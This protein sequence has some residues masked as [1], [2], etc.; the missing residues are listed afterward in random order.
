MNGNRLAT[1]YILCAFWFLGL[2][3]LHRLYNGKIGTGLLWLFTL[4]LFGVGQFVDLLLIPN[5]VDDY[6]LRL[7]ARYGLSSNGVPLTQ[8]TITETAVRP[9]DDQLMIRL[10]RAAH[11]KGGKISVTQGVMATGA[12]F[13]Q[14]EAVLNEMVKSGYVSSNNDPDTGV[15]FYHF[16]EL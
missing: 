13:A 1:S 15:V 5:V 14:V 3:G 2:G 16:H 12:N 4:G 8:S 10:L 7:R 6:E 9:T 11:P